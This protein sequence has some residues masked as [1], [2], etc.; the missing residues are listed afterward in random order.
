MR[1]KLTMLVAGLSFATMVSP[2]VMAVEAP[3]PASPVMFEK[4]SDEIGYRHNLM[5]ML[6]TYTGAI[7]AVV[8]KKYP[9]ETAEQKK[10]VEEITVAIAALAKQAALGFDQ[11]LASGTKASPK[12]WKNKPDF[13]RKMAD[14]VETASNLQVAAEY[15][16]PWQVAVRF[17][18]FCR[19]L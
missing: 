4:G 1:K 13:N 10:K 9:Y 18:G 16:R 8:K 15:R 7:G 6:G 12:I 11:E 17:W 5:D 14:L 3:A 2:L 19:Y